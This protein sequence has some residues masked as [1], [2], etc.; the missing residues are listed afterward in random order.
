MASDEFVR[1]RGAGQLPYQAPPRLEHLVRRCS[2]LPSCARAMSQE[3]SI[4]T[5]H[6]WL[7]SSRLAQE[8]AQETFVWVWLDYAPGTMPRHVELNL[9]AMHRHAPSSHGF[10][11]VTLN[12]STVSRAR[13][14]STNR[15]QTHIYTPR[16]VANTPGQ[17]WARNASFIWLNCM[18]D[19][20]VWPRMCRMDHAPRRIQSP[21]AQGCRQRRG[22]NGPACALRGILR[23]LTTPQGS[24]GLPPPPRCPSTQL[25][26]VH[27]IDLTHRPLPFDATHDR[28][29]SHNVALARNALVRLRARIAEPP[30]QHPWCTRLYVHCGLAAV[31][32]DRCRLSTCGASRTDQRAAR[33]L[34]PRAVLD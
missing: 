1:R 20:P 32:T 5:V 24:G 31:R 18:L 19:C 26:D 8:P 33:G 25:I 11:L 28:S 22:A 9:R 17:E 21:Q 4:P 34:R 29:L 12:A 16:V 15:T 23:M 7:R 6:R 2:L 13:A 27:L 30:L 10:R 14:T 3:L